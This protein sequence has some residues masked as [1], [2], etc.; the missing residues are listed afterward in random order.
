MNMVCS[1]L[2]TKK[3]PRT[4]WLESINWTI[5]VLNRSPTLAVKNKTLEEA[6]SGSK[7]SVDY[8]KT[9]GFSHMFMCLI[10]LEQNW[11]IKASVEFY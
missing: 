3:M 2:S 11:M 6:W 4:F 7:P 1:M 10:T 9:F 8:F 5:H